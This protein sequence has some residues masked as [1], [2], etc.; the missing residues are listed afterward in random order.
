MKQQYPD[1]AA[2]QHSSTQQFAGIQQYPDETA[3][4]HS[5]VCE[6]SSAVGAK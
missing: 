1:Q 4:K 6:L 2:F 3:F 5:A